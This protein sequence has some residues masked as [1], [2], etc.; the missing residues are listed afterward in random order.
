MVRMGLV[1]LRI[2]RGSLVTLCRLLGFYERLFRFPL[3]PFVRTVVLFVRLSICP[4]DFLVFRCCF[5]VGI[6]RI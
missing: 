3:S 2:V 1:T 6:Y 4:G 5:V